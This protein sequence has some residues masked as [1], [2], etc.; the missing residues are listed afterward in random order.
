MTFANQNRLV[1]SAVF[2]AAAC[3]GIP[4]A[5]RAAEDWITLFD[6]KTLKG[7]HTNPEK[8]GHGTGGIW[9]VEEGGVLAGEQ[10]PPG[11]GNGGILLTDRKFGDF[12]LSLEMKPNWGSDSGVFLRSTDKG[13]CIQMTVDYYDGGNIG[14]FYG[15]ATGA[16][17]PR[18]FSIQGVKEGDKLVSLK[19]IDARDPKSA[20][21]IDSC[22]PEEWLKA[23]KIGDWNTALI[24]VEGGK[25]PRITTHINGL[26]VG[27]FDAATAKLE[28][29]DREAV[30][31]QLGERGSIAV[32][33]H[34]GG[35]YPAGAK[36]RWR[37]IKVR[38]LE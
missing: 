17:V 14:H 10:D 2:C 4:Q 18:A 25:Y 32:Q 5:A 7:W 13:E 27:E 1:L 23:W 3:V 30:A 37:N 6:G 31:K 38:V 34:G 29:Y 12:E 8:I 36:C 35:S 11:S 20:G 33:V 15:E 28:K 26:K 21:L 9:T 22:T 19:T 24:R 16:W